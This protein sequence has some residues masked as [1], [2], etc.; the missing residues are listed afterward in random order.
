M[1]DKVDVTFL[2]RPVHHYS[3]LLALQET[4]AARLSHLR[5]ALLVHN[6]LLG[7]FIHIREVKGCSVLDCKLLLIK[8]NKELL[9]PLVL[10]FIL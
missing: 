8:F 9:L 3:Y 1:S 7:L 5:D 2:Y 6:S 10:E 4:L